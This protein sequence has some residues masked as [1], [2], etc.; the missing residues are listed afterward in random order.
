MSK[1]LGVNL[2]SLATHVVMNYHSPQSLVPV[3]VT[4]GML[5]ENGGRV[6]VKVPVF[7]FDRLP[8]ADYMLGV[9]MASTGEVACFGENRC[10]AYLKALLSAGFK[11][12]KKNI[13]VSI[14]SYKASYF[15]PF[16][17]LC[18]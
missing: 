8:G 18:F 9:E 14:G 7:S 11:L 1:T 16:S 2:V 13:L 5:L 4:G 15:I 10:L 6:G 12:P 3:G 17:V